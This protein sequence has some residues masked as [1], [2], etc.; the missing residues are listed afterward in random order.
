M[1]YNVRYFG[2]ATRGLFST[3]RSVRGIAGAIAGLCPPADIVCLQEVETAS[4][5]SNVL[6]RREH[7]AQTQL[8]RL[9]EALADV[10]RSAGLGES[11][12]GHY[13][14]AHDYRLPGGTSAYTTGLVLLVRRPLR[15]RKHNASQPFDI[16]HRL[17][18]GRRSPDGPKPWLKQTRICAHAVLEHPDGTSLDVFNTHLSLPAFY[19]R[20]FWTEDS[21]MG[22]GFN[23]MAEAT[24][25]CEFVARERQGDNYL[26]VGDFNALPGSPV[27]DL[28]TQE[29]GWSDPLHRALGGNLQRLRDFPTAGFL[30]LRM[31]LDHMLS[32]PGIQ[33]DDVSG[34]HA[35]GDKTSPFHGLSDHVPLIGRIRI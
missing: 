7:P 33:W 10:I 29:H 17:R 15:L 9:M 34:T 21:R 12:E 13:F 2:H 1:T 32:G 11:Y 31:H 35:F 25:L 18:E 6:H 20:E 30:H 24:T 8:E 5:R 27:Y 22:F 19:R 3:A 28:L 26:V 4:L 16:T 14:P 23:Q